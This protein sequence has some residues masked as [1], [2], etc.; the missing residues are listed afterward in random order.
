MRTINKTSA[1]SKIMSAALLSAGALCMAS[2]AA[3]SISMPSQL[4]NIPKAV[5]PVTQKLEY[6][7]TF[8]L[9]AK[10]AGLSK[11]DF[12]AIQKQHIGKTRGL[13]VLKVFK[14]TGAMLVKATPAAITALSSKGKA[15]NVSSVSQN[16][17]LADIPKQPSTNNLHIKT[18]FDDVASWG[19]DRIDQRY[20]TLDG[21]LNA[22]RGG[23]GVTAYILDTGTIATSNEFDNASGQTRL[24]MGYNPFR[25][26]FDSA[27]CHGHGSHVAGTV[28]GSTYGVAKDVNLVALRVME[29]GEVKTVANI[30][31]GME[32]V[33]DDVAA[34]QGP[35]VV[36]MSLSDPDGSVVWDNATQA[37]IDAGITVVVA[38]GNNFY[39]ACINS[40]A[41]LS[42][43]ITVGATDQYDHYN[44]LSNYG[45]C[46]DILA[47]GTSITS[48][49]E[50]GQ[51][52][53]ISGT[54]MAAPHVTGAAALV[55]ERHP[56]FNH[57]QVKQYLLDHATQGVISGTAGNGDTLEPSANKLLFIGDDLATPLPQPV[58]NAGESVAV[59]LLERGY[60]YYKTQVGEGADQLTIE[61]NADDE[62]DLFVKHDDVPSANPVSFHND[63]KQTHFGGNEVCEFDAPAIGDW[64]ILIASSNPAASVQLSVNHDGG[65]VDVCDT[66]P[67]SAACIC[68][69]NPTDPICNPGSDLLNLSNLA[70]SSQLVY[71]VVV[72]AGKTLTVTSSGGTG[73]AE[74][75]VNFN[76][77]ANSWW[78]SECY[79]RNSGND[80]QCVITQTQAGTYFIVVDAYRPFENVSLV[81]T[82]E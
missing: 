38:A 64:H 9:S 33:M 66:D 22:P 12:M 31:E 29:C 13:K 11:A 25:D 77:Q 2:V 67:Q 26:N 16:R 55:L 36:N 30:V 32:W 65:A 56:D 40:P 60:A 37:M 23:A 24:R 41:R 7:V 68:K 44:N 14:H 6:I 74:L 17:V 79:S 69:T 39:D 81:A 72:P 34:H 47:P 80:D 82:V 48:I 4:K 52:W 43:A 27:D 20:L 35:A 18:T 8:D 49:D 15:A 59:E 54:S 45:Q 61:I 71:E 50:N 76:E 1:A 62:V 51:P 78:D 3:K 75:F 57:H 63:C 19:I 28:G 5:M 46:V 58:V 53:T 21:K 70:S 10:R 42:D 73:D